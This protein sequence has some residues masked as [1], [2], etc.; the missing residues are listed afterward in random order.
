MF[1][2]EAVVAREVVQEAA[3]L[4]MRWF[5]AEDLSVRSKADATPVTEADLEVETLVRRRLAEAF[6]DD[7]ILGEEEGGSFDPAGRVWI[8]DPIDGTYNFSRRIPVWGTLLALQVDGQ[9]VVGVAAAPA[10]GETYEAVRGG[11]AAMNG[12]PIHVSE[13]AE[14]ERAHLLHAGI[15]TFLGHA[16]WD[17]W[18][19]TMAAAGRTRAFGDC[20]GHMLVARGAAEAMV[21]PDLNVWDFAALCVIVEEAGGRMTRADGSPLAHRR[22]VLTS[23]GVLHDEL[24]RRIGRA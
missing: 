10:L 11:G 18:I 9:G 24:V 13:V 2:R 8:V 19:D 5:R 6:P 21:E 20:W 16:G 7:R 15:E 23:N 4:A 1:R 17:G 3:A 22:S 14:I 12:E